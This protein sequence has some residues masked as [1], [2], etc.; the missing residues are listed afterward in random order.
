MIE[1]YRF[2][3]ENNAY[4]NRTQTD[5]ENEQI[6][7]FATLKAYINAKAMFNVNVNLDE[8]IDNFFENYFGIAAAPMRQFFDELQA[9][10]RYLEQTYPAIINGGVYNEVENANLWKKKTL[11]GW[12]QLIDEAYALIEP[13]KTVNPSQ[14]TTLYN[15]INLESMFPRWA[16]L[17]LYSKTYTDIEFKQAATKF[18]EDCGLHGIHTHK[19]GDAIG[20]V[21]ADWGV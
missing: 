7:H 6:S 8:L 12:M 13:L 15:N 3:Y 5:F 21:F 17:R 16:L 9:H 2:L 18:K 4:Y 19:E 20:S 10:L 1:T 11:D 14:Y